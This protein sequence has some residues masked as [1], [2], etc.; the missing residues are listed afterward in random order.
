MVMLL[1]DLISRR[2]VGVEEM[3]RD[4]DAFVGLSRSV[5]NIKCHLKSFTKVVYVL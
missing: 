1:W 3:H 4:G 5:N 2:E